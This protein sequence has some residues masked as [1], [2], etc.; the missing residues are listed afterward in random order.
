MT[1]VEPLNHIFQLYVGDTV[2][3]NGFQ[4][5]FI[6]LSSVTGVADVV[7]DQVE[8]LLLRRTMPGEIDNYCILGL[9]TLEAIKGT[10]F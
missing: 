6:Q 7:R 5:L 3:K 1:G 2:R 8:A 9:C 10:R 4:P